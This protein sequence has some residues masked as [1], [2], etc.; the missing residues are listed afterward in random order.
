MV[1]KCTTD[2]HKC[3]SEL[4]N[5]VVDVGFTI[6]PCLFSEQ[7]PRQIIMSKQWYVNVK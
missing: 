2:L 5:Y 4:L 6:K 3:D 7:I 1:C